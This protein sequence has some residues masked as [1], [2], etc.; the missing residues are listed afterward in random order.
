MGMFIGG[1]RSYALALSGLAGGGD[2]H[3]AW[4][5]YRKMELWWLFVIT[6]IN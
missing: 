3:E 1:E 2:A 4:G 6:Y 5:V